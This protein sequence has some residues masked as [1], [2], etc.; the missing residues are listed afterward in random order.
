MS[1]F[2]DET[3]RRTYMA[4]LEQSDVAVRSTLKTFVRKAVLNP[5]RDWLYSLCV[6]FFN[7][8]E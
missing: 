7:P 4:S 2:G 3:S 8:S 1:S 5:G 6:A